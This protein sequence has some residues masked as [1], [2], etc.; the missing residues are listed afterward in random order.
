MFQKNYISSFPS[1]LSETPLRIYDIT[2]HTFSVLMVIFY[3]ISKPGS[4]AVSHRKTSTLLSGSLLIHISLNFSP[5]PSTVVFTIFLL[6]F[7]KLMTI[8]KRENLEMARLCHRKIPSFSDISTYS[9]SD[10][11]ERERAR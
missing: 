10:I 1:C 3:H 2:F 11:R 8:P 6:F 5:I 7:F 4:S 9:M